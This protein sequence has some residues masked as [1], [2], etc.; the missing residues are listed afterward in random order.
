MDAGEKAKKNP[1]TGESVAGPVTLSDEEWPRTASMFSKRLRNTLCLT[2][3]TSE[4]TADLSQDYRPT[5]DLRQLGR[6]GHSPAGQLQW[7]YRV[8]IEAEVA[9]GARRFPLVTVLQP[10]RSRPA[11]AF[12]RPLFEGH[13]QRMGKGTAACTAQHSPSWGEVCA[14]WRKRVAAGPHPVDEILS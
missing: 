2:S 14:A 10:L 13:R 8:R 5:V 4:R 3:V 6:P 12:L 7:L 9:G 11:E 1:N